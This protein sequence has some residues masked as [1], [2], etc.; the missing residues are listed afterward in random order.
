MQ[1]FKLFFK[2][3]KKKSTTILIYFV[4][5]FSIFITMAKVGAND[6]SSE[7]FSDYKLNICVKD[8]DKT[9]AS[10]ALKSYIEKNHELVDAGETDDEILDSIYYQEVD[11]VLTIKNGYE[12]KISKG[13]TNGL[14]TNYKR[15]NVYQTVY[16]DNMIDEYVSVLSSYIAGGNELSSSLDKTSEAL[17]QEVSVKVK[18]FSKTGGDNSY[19]NVGTH[20]F[21]QYYAYIILALMTN[22]LCTIL[23]TVNQTEVKRRTDCSSISAFKSTMQIHLASGV[24]VAVI[25]ILFMI[26]A[27]FFIGFEF[28]KQF[29]LLLLNSIVFT[30]VAASIS[31]LIAVFAPRQNVLNMVSNVV[32]LGMCFLSG[33]FVPQDLMSDTVNKIGALL[34]AHWYMRICNMVTNLSGE[35]YS[36]EMYAKYLG[37]QILYAAALFAVTVVV[38]K[39]KHDKKD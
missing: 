32:T 9:T 17:S 29:F 13:E 23:L 37:V 11:Y 12:D 22:S 8:E 5:F 10:K 36:G 30:V 7:N 20:Y 39:A 16:A 1:V 2:I 4:I 35:V 3:T 19:K 6:N 14:F 31:L 27:N 33:I 18:N 26:L 25:W 38:S 34:P 24:F 15:P 21:F 28:N